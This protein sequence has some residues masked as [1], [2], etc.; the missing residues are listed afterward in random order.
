M[1]WSFYTSGRSGGFEGHDADE[2]QEPLAALILAV[3]LDI[4]LDEIEF[5]FHYVIKALAAH[6]VDVRCEHSSLESLEFEAI[7]GQRGNLWN[8]RREVWGVR[9]FLQA[10]VIFPRLTEH[11][12]LW[13]RCALEQAVAFATFVLQ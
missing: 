2:I 4:F 3:F 10:L 12:H 8:G 11:K 6:V 9:V 13:R 7:L 5:A 1:I